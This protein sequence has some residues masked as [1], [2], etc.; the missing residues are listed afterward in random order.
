MSTLRSRGAL[1]ACAVVASV[2]VAGC[3]SS[4][5]TAQ[6]LDASTATTFANLYVLQQSEEGFP[7]LAIAGVDSSATCQKGTPTSA[8]EDAGP[9]V[10]TTPPIP[11]PATGN[12]I[13]NNWRCYISYFVGAV[14]KH[15][16]VAYDVDVQS[17]GC[18]SASSD[19]PTAVQTPL[20]VEE[21]GEQSMTITPGGLP[22]SGQG[23]RQIPNPLWLINGC[24]SV[25]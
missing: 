21:I 24:F 1:V 4:G 13:G 7:R 3:G 11:V 18:Y 20:G 9:P 5:I 22:N 2:T 6:K 16:T 23:S 25:T 14:G 17:D 12:G 10:A 8:N 15:V 19:G